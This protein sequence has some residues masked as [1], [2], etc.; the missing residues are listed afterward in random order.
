MKNPLLPIGADAAERVP[1]AEALHA[2]AHVG[3]LLAARERAHARVLERRVA[4][5]DRAEQLDRDPRAPTLRLLR[6][7]NAADRGA[8]LAG[9]LRH[10][11][12]H[13]LEEQLVHVA[14]R[15]D[16]GAEH[17]GVQAVGFDVHAHR[18]PDDVPCGAYLRPGVARAGEGEHVLRAEVRDQVARRAD[19]E[20]ERAFGQE[21]L[22]DDE[23]HDAMRDQRRAGGGLAEH[24]HAGEQ[25]DGRLLGEA[26]GGEVERVDV[27]RDAVA[28]HRD[29]LAV[30]ARRAAELDAFAVDEESRFPSVFAISAYA[31][32]V[33][34]APSTSN[35][36]SERVL[37]PFAMPS[38]RS[39][40][41]SP[42]IASAIALSAAPRSAKLIARSA[43]PPVG[44]RVVRARP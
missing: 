33:A 44:A 32:S 12:H 18:L 30:E 19:E 26:P 24:R 38:S 1:A 27:H 31:S 43:G 4:D 17:R 5:A 42:W 35:L 37:P 13:V 10:V 3:E 29:V 2:L 6:D 34:I 22:L 9:L 16:V 36:A 28:R 8:L 41:R 21:L 7:K 20:R 14:A 40:S 11:A 25:R 15:L 39:A 23:L